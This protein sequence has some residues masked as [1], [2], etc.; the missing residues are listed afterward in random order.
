M[1]V[2]YAPPFSARKEKGPHPSKLLQAL[3]KKQRA[4]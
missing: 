1:P 2:Q 4:G 3:L